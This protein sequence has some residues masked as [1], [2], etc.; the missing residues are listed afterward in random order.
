MGWLRRGE[1]RYFYE[2]V[3]VGGRAENVYLGRCP[4]A[5]A[6]SAEVLQRRREREERRPDLQSLR[7][8]HSALA[9]PLAALDEAA[10]LLARACLVA[11]GLHEHHRMWR[12]RRGRRVET[13]ADEARL[14]ALVQ[15]EPAHG[16]WR[17][18]PPATPVG[19]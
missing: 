5:E 12:R 3:W 10:E 15:G 1:R 8:G 17:V 7:D 19:E 18:S 13:D 6:A 9:A 16:E 11:A 2:A 14:P 4:E